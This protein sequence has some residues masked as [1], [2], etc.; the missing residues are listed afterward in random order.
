MSFPHIE[1]VE[2]PDVVVASQVVI[3]DWLAKVLAQAHAQGRS[4]RVVR[5][6]TPFG[7]FLLRAEVEAPPPAG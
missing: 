4:L 6:V 2:S 1:S 3:P 5:A 7:S